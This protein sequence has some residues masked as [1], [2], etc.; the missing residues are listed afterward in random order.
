MISFYTSNIALPI[1]NFNSEM[2]GVKVVE[3]NVIR[4]IWEKHF[5]KLHY[6][7]LFFGCNVTETKTLPMFKT[8][9]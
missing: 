7:S 6:F 2:I 1:T 8:L 4:N 3:I 5:T 9:T